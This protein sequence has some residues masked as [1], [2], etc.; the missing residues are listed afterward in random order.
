MSNLT[1]VAE[2]DLLRISPECQSVATLRV[3]ISMV[4]ISKDIHAAICD[5][6]K[7]LSTFAAGM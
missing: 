4:G 1:R 7:G 3:H 6:T 5:R 2:I